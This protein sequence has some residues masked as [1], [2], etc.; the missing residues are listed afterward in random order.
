[1][2]LGPLLPDTASRYSLH[3]ITWP[4]VC[5]DIPTKEFIVYLDEKAV[6]KCAP[7]L[8]AFQVL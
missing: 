6:P 4:V 7:V 1:M 3:V 8:P 5:S 2:T